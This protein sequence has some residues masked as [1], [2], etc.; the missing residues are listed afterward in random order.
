MYCCIMGGK[1]EM[2]S[3]ECYNYSWLESYGPA[4]DDTVAKNWYIRPNVVLYL[5]ILYFQECVCAQ[6]LF[7]SILKLLILRFALRSPVSPAGQLFQPFLK[8][9]N[10]LSISCCTGHSQSFLVQF[11]GLLELPWTTKDKQ[12]W[13]NCVS[14]RKWSNRLYNHIHSIRTCICTHTH[15]DKKVRVGNICSRN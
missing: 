9:L 6:A 3:S 4:K 2:A 15:A 12:P 10:S 5:S 7:G 11:T 8:Q 14:L 13:H 1:L